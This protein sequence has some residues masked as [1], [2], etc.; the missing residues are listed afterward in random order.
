MCK[1]FYWFKRNWLFSRPNHCTSRESPWTIAH[2]QNYTNHRREVK[3]SAAPCHN[4]LHFNVCAY[5]FLWKQLFI[6]LDI[7]LRWKRENASTF[8]F[9][10]EQISC[11]FNKFSAKISTFLTFCFCE[12]LSFS[13]PLCWMEC[14]YNNINGIQLKTSKLV[15]NVPMLSCWNFVIGNIRKSIGYTVLIQQ[16]PWYFFPFCCP[17]SALFC[18]YSFHRMCEWRRKGQ[19]NK[20]E[21]EGE[22]KS[23]YLLGTRWR[24]IQ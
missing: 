18:Y 4:L 10:L 17:F 7:F 3:W 11:L 24:V 23:K 8:L 16:I 5:L 14:F 12:S 21:K 6:F 15:I 9:A 22:R 2:I 20:S 1:K 19:E 13:L